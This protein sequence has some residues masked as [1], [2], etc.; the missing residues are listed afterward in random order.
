MR[1]LMTG[2]TSFTGRC[3]LR[4]LAESGHEIWHLTRKTRGFDN[5]VIWDFMGLLPE[6]LPPCDILVH[7]AASV[8][9]RNDID[10]MQYNINTVST[11]KLAGYART[12][13]SYF[14]YAST[15]SIHGN[16][17]TVIDENTPIHPENHYAVSKYLSEEVIKTFAHRCSILRICGIYG[18]NG[19]EH[20][21]LNKALNNAV[22]KRMRPVLRG[23]GKAKRNYIC[24]HDVSQWILCLIQGHG[25][26]SSSTDTPMRETLYLAGPEVMT[27][28]EY[29]RLI[30]ET[31]LPGMGLER[32]DGP[33]STDWVV[34]A[35]PAP[36]A[37]LTFRQYLASLL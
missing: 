11:I 30:V 1:I 36:F 15:A 4:M 6:G 2:S 14:I 12:Y 17:H 35:S 33:E 7:L 22:H 26:T 31:I 21:G 32:V 28:E 8:N 16:Q 13:N 19:P 18:L 20:L 23:G 24:V 29:L 10:I 34:N 5:E 3:L 9:F 25:S 27:I 37:P